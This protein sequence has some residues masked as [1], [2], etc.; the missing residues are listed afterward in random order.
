MKVGIVGSRRY[1]NKKKIKRFHIQIKT[2]ARN[3]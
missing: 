1:E 2:R 3:K